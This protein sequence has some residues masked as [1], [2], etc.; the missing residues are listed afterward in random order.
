MERERSMEV[1]EMEGRVS[2]ESR[3]N[4]DLTCWINKG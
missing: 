1:A 2:V 3:E 4:E